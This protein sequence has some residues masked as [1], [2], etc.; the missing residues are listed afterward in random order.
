MDLRDYLRAVRK[1]WWMVVGATTVAVGVAITVTLLTPPK[2][3]ASVTF[4]ISTRGTEVTQAFQGGQF[5]QQRVK[6]YVDVLT[7]NRLAQAIVAGGPIDLDAETVQTEISAQVVPDTVL[8]EATVTDG[9]RAR[10]L[11][12]AQSLATEFPALIAKLETPPGSKVPTVGVQIIAEPR[13]AD[14]PVSP[15]P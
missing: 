14:A 8:V 3:A 1:R 7:S 10:A 13:L 15:Q 4:F 12:L 2:Y 11:Q 5:A 6:S 9:D